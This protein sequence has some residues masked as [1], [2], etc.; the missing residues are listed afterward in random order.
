MI[1]Q[2]RDNFIQ[3][4]QGQAICLGI[5]LLCLIGIGENIF[6]LKDHFTHS[7]QAPHSKIT[8]TKPIS[9]P[10]QTENKLTEW[11]LFGLTM[12]S[13]EIQQSSLPY[14]VLGIIQA[15]P[16]EEST[17]I[18]S[19]NNQTSKRYRQGDTLP[20]AGKIIKIETNRVIYKNADQTLEA[21]LLYENPLHFYQFPNKISE[22]T[23]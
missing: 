6:V 9:N 11:H 1:H 20:G 17:A 15:N 18:I 3:T 10:Y 23:P 2:I 19:Q 13:Q 21:L 12:R 14:H 16:Q 4:K 8:T 5:I 7:K 22:V